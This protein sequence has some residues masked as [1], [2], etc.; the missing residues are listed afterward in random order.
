MTATINAFVRG[1]F[2][3]LFPPAARTTTANGTGVDLV[4]LEGV[5]AVFLDS[6]AGTGT[7]PTMTVKLQ[8]SDDDGSADAYADIS[9]ATF[10]QVTTAASKQTITVDLSQAKRWIRAVTTIGGTSPSFTFSVCIAGQQKYQ[11]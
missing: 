3:S 5:A 8:H 9:G 1:I 7:T 2:N 4:A 11:S 6:A 10:A